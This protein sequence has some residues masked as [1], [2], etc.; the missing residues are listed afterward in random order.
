MARPGDVDRG[1]AFDRRLYVIRRVFEQSSEGTYVCSFSSRTVVYKGMF[2][3]NQLRKFYLDLQD[4]RV[5]S[6]IAM[7]HSRF[8]TNTTP[9]WERAHPNRLILH[10]GEINTIRGNADRMLAREETMDSPGLS[11]EDMGKVLPVIAP[12]GSDSA[13]LDNTLEFLMMNGIPLPL[14][15]M[16]T[17]P[18]PWQKDTA[19]DRK[20][21]DMYRYYS[22]MMEPWDGPA[23][24]FFS[25]GD[26]MGAVLDRNGLRPARYYITTDRRLVLSSEVGVLD[27]PPE[28]ILKK[29]RLQPG[30][31]LLVDTVR[32]KVIS[33]EECKMALRGPSALRRMAG[34]VPG[35][36]GG[37]AGAQQEGG[38]LQPGPA[39]QA[40]QG[41]RLH[42]RGHYG[43]HCAHGQAGGRADL[44]HGHGY[45]SGG[46]VRE[47][48]APFQLLQAALC[49]GDQPAHRCPAG[50][51]CHGYL[52]V[53]RLRRQPP[54]GEGGKLPG[55]ANQESHHH[56]SGAD[57]DQ[58]H[59]AA[60]G[61]G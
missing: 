2:L 5:E 50:G 60:L 28:K 37:A 46:A 51:N 3:V 54:S 43:R 38:T 24:I 33:D 4:E 13:M 21:R 25:D 27:I 47:A 15:V 7:V 58:G 11:E 26:I 29:S 1:L 35:D 44:L 32:K 8:S 30:K 55:A 9:S 16:M 10:N 19:M 36:P 42:L 23:A 6:A 31:M 12:T 14:A 52:R 56:L 45:P 49:P 34:P 18:E 40:L 57:A 39:G 59:E 17:I 22:T 20:K 41:L 61:S 48:P 53:Y